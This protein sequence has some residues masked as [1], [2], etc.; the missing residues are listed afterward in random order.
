MDTDAFP[1]A[2]AV[3]A[4]A[5]QSIKP[6][7]PLAQAQNQLA[8]IK[9]LCASC[10]EQLEQAA[11]HRAGLMDSDSRRAEIQRTIQATLANVATRLRGVQ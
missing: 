11:S 1:L 10:A 8:D 2:V 5:D 7:G 3:A 6:R 9:E 4:A